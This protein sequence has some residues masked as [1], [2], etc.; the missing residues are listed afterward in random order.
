MN[1]FELRNQLVDNYK[2]YISSFIQIR[3]KR[4]RSHVDEQL[5]AGLLWPEPLIKLNT[6]F[7]SAHNIYQLVDEVL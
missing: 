2:S 7:Q 6:A 5:K 4:I 1:V 3:D